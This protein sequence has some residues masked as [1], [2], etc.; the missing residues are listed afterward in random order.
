MVV[1]GRDASIVRL[2][3]GRCVSVV[4]FNNGFVVAR[5]VSLVVIC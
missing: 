5:I 1:V 2:L 4:T 3:I